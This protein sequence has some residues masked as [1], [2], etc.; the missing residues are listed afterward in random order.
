MVAWTL[1]CEI[2]LL[3]ALENRHVVKYY[4]HFD[5]NGF[6]YIVMEYVI[7]IPHLPV[8]VSASSFVPPPVLTAAANRSPLRCVEQGSLLDVLQNFG[9]IPEHLVAKYVSEVLQGLSFLHSEG[10]LSSFD[11][12]K[13]SCIPFLQAHTCNWNS[14][15]FPAL[16]VSFIETSRPPTFSSLKREES[17]WQILVWPPN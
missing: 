11:V 13:K 12:W 1:Q 3:S 17:S 8:G 6:F 7:C 14:L 15:P 10:Q 4:E 16:Q 2:D 5:H 9:N